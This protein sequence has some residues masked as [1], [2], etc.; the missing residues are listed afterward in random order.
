MKKFFVET[1]YTGNI[2]IGNLDKL[3]NKIIVVTTV[4]Y[5]EYLNELIKCLKNAGK[6]PIIGKTKQIYKGQ[7]LGCDV[8]L[9]NSKCD[10]ILYLGDGKFHPTKLSF[11]YDKPVYLLEPRTGTITQIDNKDVENYKKK[12]KGAM[13]KF[14]TSNHIGVLFTT[15]P[16]QNQKIEV[17]KKLEKKYPDKQFYSFISETINFDSLQDFTFIDTWV[18]TACPRIEE[19]LRIVNFDDILN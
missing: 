4:Q 12:K 6:K 16:G 15:K 18:N 2:K 11:T 5:R 19:D 8:K 14:L 1:K 7:I 3:P 9:E 13:L 10:C 17:T